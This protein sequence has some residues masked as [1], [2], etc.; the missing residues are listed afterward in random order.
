MSQSAPLNTRYSLHLLATKTSDSSP[1]LLVTFDDARYL[2]NAPESISRICVQNK[3]GMK[4]VGKVFLGELCES[5]GLPGVIFTAVE[6]G[7]HKLEVIGPEGLDHLVSS[8]RY[9]TRR[10]AYFYVV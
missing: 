2:F 9:F 7:N 1:S 4:K 6:S 10:F 5:S 8:L 3:V